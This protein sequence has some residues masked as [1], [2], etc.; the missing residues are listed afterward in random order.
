[1]LKDSLDTWDIIRTEDPVVYEFFRSAPGGVPTQTAFSQNRYYQTLDG[2]RETGEIRNAEHA[3][4]KDGG[5]AVLY[6][7]I[8]VD[9]CIVKTAGVDD[10]ILKFNV[11]ARVFE[12]QDAAVDS[13]LGHEI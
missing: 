8:A 6:G 11:T 12:S 4:S 2:N 5:L 1:T 7:N 10:S 13:I 9:G 3:F